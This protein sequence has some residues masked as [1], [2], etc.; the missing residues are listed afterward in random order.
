[1]PPMARA[2]RL[3]A[4]RLGLGSHQRASCEA[5][6]CF[7]ENVQDVLDRLPEGDLCASQ[8]HDIPRVAARGGCRRYAPPENSPFIDDT[9]RLS[10]CRYSKDRAE[11][12][13]KPGSCCGPAAFRSTAR[14]LTPA[15]HNYASGL[16]PAG[17]ARQGDPGLGSMHCRSRCGRR[18]L[19][20]SPGMRCKLTRWLNGRICLHACCVRPVRPPGTGS[21]HGL[22]GVEVG[23]DTGHH[24]PE[25]STEDVLKE[26][27]NRHRG[28][29]LWL[30]ARRFV[31]D[32]ARVG[33][34]A[35]AVGC[36]ACG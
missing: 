14:D 2:S 8:N 15:G 9:K 19:M 6:R 36:T 13:C 27:V 12:R 22:L 28:V 25:S 3:L 32:A 11:A 33:A 29:A 34:N 10:P 31:A 17:V 23:D 24:G 35:V 21:Q 30:A 7:L 16:N 18:S 20:P 5:N 4:L 26:E 1:M